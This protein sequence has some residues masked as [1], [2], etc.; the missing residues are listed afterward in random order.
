MA[1]ILV[2][3]D[4]PSIVSVLSTLLGKKGHEVVPSTGADEALELIR[5]ERFDLML[6]DI[7][8]KPVNGLELLAE[9]R[10]VS[11][12]TSVVLITGYGSIKT[13]V[14]AMRGGAFDYVTKPFKL[15]EL[16]LTVERAIDYHNIMEENVGLKARLDARARLDDIVAES[17][18]MRKVCEMI[19]RIAPTDATVLLIGESGTGKEIVA[20]A[21]HKQSR[22]KDKPFIPINCAA[23]PEALL[24]SEMFGHV[25]GAFTGAAGDK[26]GLFEAAEG[27]TV[28]LDEIGAMPRSMQAKI[29]RFLQ[30]KHIRKVGGTDTYAVE[31]RVLAATN[32]PLEKKIAEGNFREDL[33]YR[34]SV[35]P[36]E[37]PPLRKRVEDIMPLASFFIQREAGD[38]PVTLEADAQRLLEAYEWPG[39]VRE[40]ENAIRH[41][42]TFAAEGH[43]RAGDLPARIASTVPAAGAAPVAAFGGAEDYRGRSLRAFLR[44]QEKAYV[45]AVIRRM[46]G[47]KAKAAKALNISLATLYRKLPDVAE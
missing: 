4:E 17:A 10:A 41:A 3:D 33:F 31:V 20:R 15:D 11:P 25:K 29:L 44:S 46:E 42:V 7:K 23:M 1:R 12:V 19:E 9:M 28:L 26:E 43:I 21:I 2:V 35:I 13:A 27:G 45:M 24:E 16:L 6:T 38:R 39:N 40:L 8:M 34:L 36:I 5:K 30:D 47:D 22:R 37:I 14:E 18:G 32:D